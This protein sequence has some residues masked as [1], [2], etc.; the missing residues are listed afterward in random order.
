[1]VDFDAADGTLLL[2]MS[3]SCHGCAASTLTLKHGIQSRL[4]D[5]VPEVRTVEAI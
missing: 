4:R 3:G 1:M 5:A 2:R